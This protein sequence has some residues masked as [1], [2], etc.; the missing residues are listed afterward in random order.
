VLFSG[1]GPGGAG[2]GWGAIL[3]P[4]KK[5][6]CPR[7]LRVKDGEKVFTQLRG[8]KETKGATGPYVVFRFPASPG[9]TVLTLG[10]T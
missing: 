4:D 7:F 9:G 2:V 5:V 10:K 1:G 3:L 8:D 6:G